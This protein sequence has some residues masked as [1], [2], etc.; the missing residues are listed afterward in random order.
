V[1]RATSERQINENELAFDTQKEA[2][3]YTNRWGL[4]SRLR[5]GI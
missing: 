5:S 3:N 2:E 1:R 4:D